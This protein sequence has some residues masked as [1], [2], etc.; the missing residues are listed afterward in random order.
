MV[1][2][3][4]WLKN[5]IPTYISNYL[6]TQEVPHND[7]Y[8]HRAV[9]VCDRHLSSF[10]SVLLY[11]ERIIIGM[12][13]RLCNTCTRILRFFSDIMKLFK[14]FSTDTADSHSSRSCALSLVGLRPCNLLRL[15]RLFGH[16]WPPPPHRFLGRV[17]AIFLAVSLLCT[18]NCCTW[19]RCFRF[20]HSSELLDSLRYHEMNRFS[21]SFALHA[22]LIV[23]ILPSRS[24]LMADFQLQVTFRVHA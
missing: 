21:F 8:R 13:C 11:T 14:I 17:F 7:I 3:D 10:L 22:H 18:L 5:T 4:K 15:G 19:I 12:R 16:V 1:I 9:I 20:Y 23:Y 6:Q 2:I 24:G